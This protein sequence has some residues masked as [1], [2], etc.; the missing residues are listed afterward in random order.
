MMAEI[1]VKKWRAD[2]F[3]EK[4]EKSR[5]GKCAQGGS[6][7]CGRDAEFTIVY[8]TGEPIATCPDHLVTYVR[9]RLKD[10]KSL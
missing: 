7:V 1:E 8:P 9:T 10:D 6:G 3:T 4:A 2:H 5:M